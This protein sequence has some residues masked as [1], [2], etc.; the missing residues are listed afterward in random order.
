M[1]GMCLFLASL[2]MLFAAAMLGYAL[3]RLSAGGSA[4]GTIHIPRPLAL[5]TALLLLSSITIERAVYLLHREKI[6]A[7]R[8]QLL[9]T[10]I[11]TL[12]FIAVQVPS[13]ADL[14][15]THQAGLGRGVTIYGLVFVL[16]LLHALH[17]IGGVVP[18]VV[19]L[20]LAQR[21]RYDHECTTPV[22][23]LALYWHFLGMVWISMLAMFALLN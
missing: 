20:R 15:S 17:V 11:L 13:L 4:G 7:F 1:I 16:I 22:R 19:T 23:S 2:V 6:A 12:A 21:G 9:F 14:L 3:V 10:F 5:S 8:R 18:L